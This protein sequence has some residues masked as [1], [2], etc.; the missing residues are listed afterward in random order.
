MFS[1]T[2]KKIFFIL[3]LSLV[4]SSAQSAVIQLKNG[5]IINA[6]VLE[7]SDSEI[8]IAHPAFG[9]I[10]IPTAQVTSVNGLAFTVA[11][12]TAVEEIKEN[13]DTAE[14]ATEE[15]PGLLGFNVDL[16]PG[17]EHK[18][19]AGFNGKQGNTNSQS[20][21][22]EYRGFFE[23]EQK[24]WEIRSVYDFND[25]G[26]DD[27]QNE[28]YA[29]ATRD[30]LSPD[31]EWFYFAFGKYQWDEFKSWDHKVSA[32]LGTGYEFIN[33]K[34]LLLLGRLGLAGE[35]T[36]GGPEPGFTP[37]LMAGA[38]FKKTFNEQHSLAAKTSFYQ[39]FDNTG[40][41]NISTLDWDIS[42]DKLLGLG[43]RLGLENEHE[44]QPDGND[45]HNDFKYKLSLVWGWGS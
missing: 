32:T 15:D 44:S 21:H 23:N 31:S 41:R 3:S 4:F 1:K 36:V 38:D 13:I 14:L 34:D 30:W 6:E 19:G 20:A 11:T 39:S 12:E 16:F 37:E 5:D 43:L 18:L 42:I 9:E 28:F 10:S 8:K 26:D 33:R 7:R 40:W 35:Q 29:Q 17:W 24:R 27:A 25:G 45:V 22:A 2:M